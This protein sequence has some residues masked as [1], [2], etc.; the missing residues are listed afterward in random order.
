MVELI[1][2][3][4][5][6]FTHNMYILLKWLSDI[7]DH[8]LK[9]DI[10]K[11]DTTNMGYCDRYP[12]TAYHDQQERLWDVLPLKIDLLTVP[13]KFCLETPL[14]ECID[15]GRLDCWK[16]YVAFTTV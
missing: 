9:L 4:Y 15:V 5:L 10:R 16:V 12:N 3:N 8:L 11:D 14:L 7:T 2:I 13:Q 1:N 6:C